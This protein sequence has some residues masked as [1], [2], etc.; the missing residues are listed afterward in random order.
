MNV[1]T[2]SEAFLQLDK[3]MKNKL[4]QKAIDMSRKASEGTINEKDKEDDSIEEQSYV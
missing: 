4:T 3:T 2:T 1:R